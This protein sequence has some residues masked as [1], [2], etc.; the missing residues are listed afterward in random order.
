MNTRTTTLI[1]GGSIPML[2]VIAVLLYSQH[3]AFLNWQSVSSSVASS[4]IRNTVPPVAITAVPTTG[5]AP[6]AVFFFTFQN[7]QGVV[8]FGDGSLPAEMQPT[9][10]PAD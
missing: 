7:P 10:I 3:P 8:R 9:S 1:V 4:A 5:T 2:G 6:L